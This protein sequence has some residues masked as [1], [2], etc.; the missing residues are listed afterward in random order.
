MVATTN[1]YSTNAAIIN[2]PFQRGFS[3]FFPLESN[4]PIHA[5]AITILSSSASQLP[6]VTDVR[7]VSV[8]EIKL[9]KD[10]VHGASGRVCRGRFHVDF[11]RTHRFL[12]GGILWISTFVD[13]G[14][15]FWRNC[16]LTLQND[17]FKNLDAKMDAQKQFA[18]PW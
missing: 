9:S 15:G 12:S 14:T 10:G 13:L 17:D 8:V 7:N 2:H 16:S 11:T 6:E 3:H 1:K 18:H 4:R 5:I